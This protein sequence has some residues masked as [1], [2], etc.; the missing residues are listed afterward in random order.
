MGRVNNMYAKFSETQTCF[1]EKFV[2]ALNEWS[3]TI[4]EQ[5]CIFARKSLSN[6]TGWFCLS[7]FLKR[8]TLILLFDEYR[9]YFGAKTKKKSLS[10]ILHK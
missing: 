5:Y 9:R 4:L 6:S 3:F 1:S 10:Y 7:W 2:H 8:F